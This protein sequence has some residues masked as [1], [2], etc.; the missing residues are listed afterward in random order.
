MVFLHSD[1]TIKKPQHLIRYD[2][3]AEELMAGLVAF[4]NLRIW[5]D[6]VKIRSSV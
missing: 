2:V 1:L 6:V 3:L 5:N 4:V